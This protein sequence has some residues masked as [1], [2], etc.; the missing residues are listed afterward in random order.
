VLALLADDKLE[1]A[2]SEIRSCG[3][4][5]QVDEYGGSIF[6]FR[7]HSNGAEDMKALV[8][9]A[10]ALFDNGQTAHPEMPRIAA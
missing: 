1:P 5:A 4:L 9:E 8:E 6:H 3:W 10:I 2:K 7:P